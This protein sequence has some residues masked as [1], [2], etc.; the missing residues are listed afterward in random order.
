MKKSIACNV[1]NNIIFNFKAGYRRPVRGKIIKVRDDGQVRLRWQYANGA[2][3]YDWVHESLIEN[4]RRCP[5]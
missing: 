5:R 2:N 1:G 4:V 3:T